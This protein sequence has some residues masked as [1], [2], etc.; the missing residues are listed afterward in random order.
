MKAPFAVQLPIDKPS[1]P[2]ATMPM[3]PLGKRI[4]AM[5][6]NWASP[7]S[8]TLQTRLPADR[9]AI[10][11]TLLEK[12]MLLKSVSLTAISNNS[13]SNSSAAVI[14]HL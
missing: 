8:R 13:A 11:D 14:G 4:T 3:P 9:S 7:S 5:R 1:F 6:W 2:K 12:L 10:V